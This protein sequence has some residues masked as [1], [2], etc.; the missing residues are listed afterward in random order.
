[1]RRVLL[2]ERVQVAV[3]TALAAALSWLLAVRVGGDVLGETVEQYAYYAPLGAVVATYP[4]VAASAR[5]A[6]S[7]AL[8]VALGGAIG[9]AVHTW[10]SPGVL[11]LALVVLAGVLLGGLPVLGG[12]GS[13][14]TIAAMFVLVIGGA[15]A[16]GYTLAYVGLIALGGAVGVAVNLALPALRLTPG[17]RAVEDAR[18]VLAGQLDDLA[19][20]LRQ[21]PPP[22]P[23]QW[24]ARMRSIT[25]VIQQM[26]RRVLEA[27]DATHG[28]PR[29]RYHRG[30]VSDQRDTSRALERVAVLVEDLVALLAESHRGDLPT[31]PLD[32]DLAETTAG[33]LD[34][35]A[36]LVRQYRPHPAA[37]DPAVQDVRTA[38]QRLTDAFGRR[39]DLDASDVAVLG[40]VVAN[41][42]RTLATIAPVRQPLEEPH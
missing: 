8:A 10:L 42:R 21:H 37:D 3:K 4:T 2:D 17:R 14:V 40:A 36:A 31:T 19:D 38:V 16:D 5:S 7:A 15:D 6:G 26:R 35:L 9:L 13:Y 28:N 18:Q 29:A 34:C 33:A 23:A 25:P 32:A 27:V 22:E 1:V 12:H 30:E 20:A 11:T 24:H 39:R 41:L